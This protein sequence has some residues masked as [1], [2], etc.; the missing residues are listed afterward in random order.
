MSSG[1]AY[2][3][4]IVYGNYVAE[5]FTNIA[6]EIVKYPDTIIITQSNDMEFE[7]AG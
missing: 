5:I 2:T 4:Y 6:K 3:F 7:N 1:S